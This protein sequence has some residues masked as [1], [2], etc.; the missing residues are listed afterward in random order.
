MWLR[1]PRGEQGQMT[2]QEIS[3]HLQQDITLQPM[4]QSGDSILRSLI[5]LHL[6]SLCPKYMELRYQHPELPPIDEHRTLCVPTDLAAHITGRHSL[7]AICIRE[8]Q[9]RCDMLREGE[10]VRTEF[11]ASSPHLFGGIETISQIN[12]HLP[13]IF[14]M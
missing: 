5:C 13:P 14:P 8:T 9:T 2:I 3:H 12:G 10:A 7:V 1:N 4:S 6:F 11:A